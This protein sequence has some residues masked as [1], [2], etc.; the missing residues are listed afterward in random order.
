MEESTVSGSVQPGSWTDPSVS[1]VATLT[2]QAASD[3]LVLQ[4]REA[5]ALTLPLPRFL[6][7]APFLQKGVASALGG[8]QLVNVCGHGFGANFRSVAGLAALVGP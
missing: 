7:P 8:F 4:A 2:G 3:R 6:M 5:C 1:H